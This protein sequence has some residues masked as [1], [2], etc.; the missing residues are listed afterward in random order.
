MRTNLLQSYK[1]NPLLIPFFQFE[2]KSDNSH[3]MK[4]E[5]KHPPY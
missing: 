1:K 4:N 5:R 3:R 2:L